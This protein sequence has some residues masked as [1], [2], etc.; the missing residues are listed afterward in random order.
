MRIRTRLSEATRLWP[1]RS[2]FSR[3]C[4]ASSREPYRLLGISR[5]ATASDI[6]KAFFRTAKQVHPDINP[7]PEAAAEFRRLEAAYRLL[8]D[9]NRRRS[10]DQG[11]LHEADDA[12]ADPRWMH[13][14]DP[15]GA[16][17]RWRKLMEDREI[18]RE[19]LTGVKEEIEED[20]AELSK[21]V[22]SG[23]FSAVVTFAR[24]Q[25]VIA[26]AL[27]VPV[28]LT[29]YPPAAL[30]VLRLVTSP[31]VRFFA[32]MSPVWV[33]AVPYAI[34]YHIFGIDLSD[35]MWRRMVERAKRRNERRANQRIS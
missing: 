35:R 19:A 14:A 24:H 21:R 4:T 23:D 5:D 25:P 2:L 17:A 6:K 33:G 7:S 1:Q 27:C 13:H 18:L 22:S 9:E 30:F 29:R 12:S 11:N 15:E 34:M 20:L 3:F 31:S 16:R 28:L 32:Y 26:A 10:Y 8:A